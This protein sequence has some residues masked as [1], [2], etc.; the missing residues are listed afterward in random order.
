MNAVERLLA[1]ADEVVE[2]FDALFGDVPEGGV[3]SNAA[4]FLYQC[5][6]PY[7]FIDFHAQAIRDID[8]P[9]CEVLSDERLG[10]IDRWECEGALYLAIARTLAEHTPKGRRHG[11]GSDLTPEAIVA[12]C[13]IL[14]N[15]EALLDRDAWLTLAADVVQESPA[16]AGANGE[17]MK[18][19]AAV[20]TAVQSLWEL[21][22]KPAAREAREHRRHRWAGPRAAIV[23]AVKA[24]QPFAKPPTTK[25]RDADN[26]RGGRTPNDPD[27]TGKLVSGWKMFDQRFDGP[28]RAT[29]PKYI[30]W[31]VVNQK[32]ATVK[33]ERLI[34][35][36]TPE[37]DKPE[38][39]E[40]VLLRWL[41][42]GLTSEQP[43][44][45]KR[46][47]ATR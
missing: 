36:A 2:L 26:N 12:Y 31:F 38:P 4:R 37:S 17:V 20:R 27:I 24:L 13:A 45:R 40:A 35:A 43:S 14:A 21:D 41:K 15:R 6:A 16:W 11:D 19:A 46:T 28:G 29:K 47:A 32:G 42:T 7:C 34:K 33:A 8:G 18:W 22:P 39:V 1:R 25:Q 23:G 5:A 10:L 3:G 44:R 30:A 9:Y